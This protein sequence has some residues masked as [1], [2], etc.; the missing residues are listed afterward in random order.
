MPNDGLA[1]AATEIIPDDPRVIGNY[2]ILDCLD[3]GTLAAQILMR[4]IQGTSDLEDEVRSAKSFKNDTERQYKIRMEIIEQIYNRTNGIPYFTS[5]END[6]YDSGVAAAI[7]RI[8][9]CLGVKSV[10]IT[11][12]SKEELEP[13]LSHSLL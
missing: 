3:Q 5:T 4:K 10:D 7:E 1:E 2:Q 11:K 12:L 13:L 8:T 6:R 9:K